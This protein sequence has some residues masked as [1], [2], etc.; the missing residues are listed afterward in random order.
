M[1]KEL[2]I[3]PFNENTDQLGGSWCYLGRTRCQLLV[4]GDREYVT[5]A[6]IGGQGRVQHRGFIWTGRW[7]RV[8]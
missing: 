1:Y 6:P 3:Q 4:D 8:S 5:L 2:S 7:A